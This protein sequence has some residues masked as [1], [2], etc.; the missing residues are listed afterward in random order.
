[1]NTSQI[2][3]HIR[4]AIIIFCVAVASA[5]AAI[6]DIDSAPMGTAATVSASPNVM[7]MLDDSGSMDW[8]YLP[9]NAKNFSGNY[10]YNSSHCNG[11]YYNPNITYKVPVDS[12]GIPLNNSAQTSFTAAYN[13]GYNTGAGTVN[14]NTAF[15]GGSG[16][17]SS[18]APSY[19]GPAFYYTYTGTQTA[20]WQMNYYNTSGTFYTECNSGSVSGSSPGVPSGSSPFTLTVMSSASPATTITVSGPNGATI[21]VSGSSSTKVSGIT[22]NG[23]QILNATTGSSSS[24]NTIAGKIVTGINACTT[25]VTGNCTGTGYSA[26]CPGY[27]SCTSN[28]VTITGPGTAAGYNPSVSNASGYNGM[29][30]AYTAFPA[31]ASTLVSSIKVNNSVELLTSGSTASTTTYTTLASLIATGINASGYSATVS[32]NTVTVTGPNSASGATVSIKYNGGSTTPPSGGL[33]VTPG[34][35]STQS[36]SAQLQNFANWYSYYSH[37]MLMMKSGLGLAFA[38]ITNAYRVGFMTMNNNVSPDFVDILPFAGNCAAGSGTC[39]KDKWYTKLYASVAANSTPLREALSHVG[40]LYAHKFGT[41]TT[42]RATITVGGSGSTGVTSITVN[43]T[44]TQNCTFTGSACPT[45]TTTG[46]VAANIANQINAMVQTDYGAT[47][48]GNVVTITGIAGSVGYAPVI[49]DDGGGMTFTTNTFAAVTGATANL[50]GVTPLDPMQYSC[51]QNF[52]ILSTD[53]FWNGPNTYDLN[54]NAIGQQDN[55]EPRPMNDGGTATTQ[56]MTQV[57]QSTS[58]LQQL[59]SRTDT[60]QSQISQLQSSSSVLQTQTSQLQSQTSTL[61]GTLSKVLMQCNHTSATCGTAPATGL[62]NANWFVVTSG[63]CTVGTNVQCSVIS[64]LSTVANVTTTCNTSASITSTSAYLTITV[65][66]LS[67]SKPTISSIKI[68]GHE[69]L[70]GTTSAPSSSST[71]KVASAINSN[72]GSNGYTATVSGSVVTVAGSTYPITA[73]STI[74]AYTVASG[75]ATLAG[76]I[77]GSQGY[78]LNN[79]DSNGKIYSSCAYTGWS[80]ATGTPSCTAVAQSGTPNNT[81]V[82]SAVK[83]ATVVTSAWANA[84]S[85]GVTTTP[86]SSGN[87]T[88]CQYAIPGTSTSGWSTPVNTSSCTAVAQSASPTYTVGTTTQCSYLDGAWTPAS[89]CTAVAKTSSS[90]YTVGASTQCQYSLGASGSGAYV[91]ASSCATVAQSS[92]SPYTVGTATDCQT[93]VSASCTPGTNGCS[94]FTTGPTLVASC[95]PASASSAN[96]YT[97]TTCQTVTTGPTTVT[98]CTPVSASSANNYTAT[99]C[100]AGAGGTSNTLADVAEY[101]YV[102]DLRDSSLGNCTGVGTVGGITYGPGGDVCLDDVPTSN[103]DKQTQQHMT[104]FTLGLGARGSM[105]FSPIYQSLTAACNPATDGDFCAIYTGVTASGATAND[106]STICSWQA[107]GTCTWPVPSSGSINNIDD[108]WHA[109]V[110]GRGAYY[111]ATDPSTLATGLASTLAGISARLGSSAAATTSNP[112]VSAGNNFVFSSSFMSGD[113][114]GEVTRE[115]INLTTGALN[116]SGSPVCNPIV[117]WSAQGALDTLAAQTAGGGSRNIYTYNPSAST[118]TGDPAWLNS[119]MLKSFIWANMSA[120]EQ[121]YLNNISGLSQ[122]TSLTSAQQTAAAGANLLS[123]LRGDISNYG[124][125]YRARTHILG[126]VVNSKIAYVGQPS[127]SYGD[128]NYTTFASTTQRNSMVYVGANDGMLHAF[129]AGGATITAG[130][131]SGYEAWAYIPDLVESN[132]YLLAD[133]SYATLHRFF[134]DGSPIVGDICPQTL[135]S[136]CSAS[137]IGTNYSSSWRT[138]LVGGLNDGGAGYY[139]LDVTDPAKPQALWEFTD[140]NMGYSFGNPQITKLADGTWVVLLT[141]G[142]NNVPAPNGP[143]STGDGVGRLYVLNAYTGALIRTISTGVGSVGTPSGLARI[144]ARVN[145]PSSDN[146]ALE[147]YGGDLLGNVWRFDI[148]NNVGSSLQNYEAQLIVTLQDSSGNVQPITT[149]PEVGIV[150][151]QVAV[152]VGTGKFLGTSDLTNTLVQTMYGIKDPLTVS[153]T[154]SPGTAIYSS[155]QASTCSLTT[156]TNCFVQQ[157]AVDTTCPS[158]SPATICSAGYPVRTG[159]SKSVNFSTQYG[160]Y[161]NFP[162][163]GERDNTDPILALGTL[164]FTTNTP[165]TA[166]ACSV[167]GYSFSWFLNYATGAAVAT[168]TTGVI[169]VELGS[170]NASGG[171]SSSSFGNSPTYYTL[172]NGTVMELTT[173]SSG[174]S[175]LNQPP[176][177]GGGGSTRRTSW[178]ELILQ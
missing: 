149:K 156:T 2:F 144:S 20:G 121:G 36:S 13:D 122:Y 142:Y 91:N 3:N 21:T 119:G 28:V 133:M 151:N 125:Y 77:T 170:H 22:V 73:S 71:S 99:T 30:Y 80:A 27:P 141:S 11:V 127:F 19:A 85:C 18:S 55:I 5:H 26:T 137:V 61:Q 65:S 159:S 136:T 63:T 42:Y 9:D 163:S 68:D 10:G 172:P 78:T 25:T 167:G 145:N 46:A 143:Q 97:T 53:G 49:T 168:S 164:G 98:S 118:Y 38:P 89:S 176:V 79:A 60:L 178:R 169:S 130:D 139:A 58:Q 138:I 105:V 54:N 96:N 69:I 8:D 51:Q 115:S 114:T 83:C 154:A 152:F 128:T 124:T 166:N 111:S 31:I 153:T 162:S 59:Q 1:M 32:G 67:S 76:A 47:V 39:Q 101:Y 52:V 48:S 15:P 134:V 135:P 103:L 75:S 140:P 165:S 45:G 35:F 120:T 129:N 92:S 95:T 104:T 64:G 100:T 106:G 86:D 24:R 155:P 117:D 88:Q 41:I 177:S 87:T 23:T 158:G 146:T 150:S 161:I 148:N 131:G 16:S 94:S 6:T 56:T 109:A 173:L 29:T 66:G 17:G 12:T 44:E 14:L 74:T 175:S 82:A 57:W 72:V 147:V 34:T 7:V 174:G 70:T 171:I 40:Q 116:C 113:W 50:N 110:N 4:N 132:L 33:T 107:S 37:R 123:Y 43:G 90:P 93:I 84:S 81:S 126:D 160:W 108:L 157:T 102:T 62:A 112:N